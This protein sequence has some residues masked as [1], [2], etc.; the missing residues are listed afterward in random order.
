MKGTQRWEPSVGEE[1][2]EI[3]GGKNIP[4]RVNRENSDPGMSVLGK[5]TVGYEVRE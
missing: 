3:T 5:G 2:M 4:G 1:G